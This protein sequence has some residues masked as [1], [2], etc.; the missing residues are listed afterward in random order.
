MDVEIKGADQVRKLDVDALLLLFFSNEKPLKGASGFTDWRMDGFISRLIISGM[1]TGARGEIT[2][3]D[4]DRKIR[5]R[6]LL[7]V[8]LGESLSFTEKS[9]A[10]GVLKA[11]LKL[12]GIKARSF[13]IALPSEKL[14]KG[15]SP[16]VTAAILDRIKKEIKDDRDLTFAVDEKAVDKVKDSLSE[17]LKKE[18]IKLDLNK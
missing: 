16:P 12:K 9:I 1:V 7:L 3:I 2:L 14:I 4:P 8:G 13:A 15:K 11:V 10:N 18:I 6:S 17:F 5:T